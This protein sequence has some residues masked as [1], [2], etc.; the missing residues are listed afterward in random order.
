M[1]QIVYLKSKNIYYIGHCSNI[2]TG[3]YGSKISYYD[4][5]A[6]GTYYYKSEELQSITEENQSNNTKENYELI[7]SNIRATSY[8]TFCSSKS[9]TIKIDN[10]YFVCPRAGNKS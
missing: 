8:E 10:D 9:L 7:S 5:E 4:I 2:G 6:N 1:L 3:E